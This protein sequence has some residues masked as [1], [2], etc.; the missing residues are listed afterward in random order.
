MPGGPAFPSNDVAGAYSYVQQ[1]LGFL[2]STYSD[3]SGTDP[4]TTVLPGQ[5]GA[6][7]G[8]SSVT[9]LTIDGSSF[10]FTISQNF[11]F[12]VARV[13]LR[14]TAGPAGAATNTRVFFRL[15]STQTAD[16]DYQPSSTYLSVPDAAG[17]PGSPL[18]GAGHTTLPFFATGNDGAAADYAVGGPNIKD[19]QISTGDNVWVYYG[20]F[21]NVYDAGN[22]I[23]GKPVQQ[24]LNGTHHCLVAQLAFDDAPV[25]LGASP[26]SSDKLAQRNLQVTVSDNPGPASTHRVPQTF[27]IRPS[28]PAGEGVPLRP[29]EL[30]IDWGSVPVGSTASIYWPQVQASDVLALANSLYGSHT[31][32]AADANTITC[33]ITGGVTYVPVPPSAGENFAGLLTVD[34]PQ[35]IVAGAEF[36]VVVRRVG[37]RDFPPIIGLQSP[38]STVDKPAR[39]KAAA[40]RSERPPQFAARDQGW[41]YVVGTFQ[42]T[43]PVSTGP[44]MLGAE[45]NT[46]A[47]MKWRLENLPLG[48]RWHPVIDR[49]VRYLSDRVD[50]L[51]GNAGAIGPSPDGVP[52]KVPPHRHHRQVTGTVS[53]IRYD[54][55]G[56][57]EGFVLD[58]CEVHHTFSSRRRGIAEVALLACRYQLRLTVHLDD[59]GDH[60]QRLTI[61]S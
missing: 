61:N 54:C 2:N 50:G 45:E 14:G 7:Q 51:G 19:V 11:N 1:L 56:D 6:L 48:D 58:C 39:G 40:R 46:L 59:D 36:T 24:W 44:A 28:I 49:F 17:Q 21:L 31:L 8:D 33:R 32:A 37:T 20:C 55:Y 5:S 12:A 10:P 26:Q 30:M 57:F 53:E 22:I 34:L 16:T 38:P 42:V 35:G 29:D 47:I 18:V 15:W 13:R 27:D 3:P 41:R 4:F 43:I 25:F 9:P 52:V 60:I 23:D